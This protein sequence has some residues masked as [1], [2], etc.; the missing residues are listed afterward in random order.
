MIVPALTTLLAVA[1]RILIYTEAVDYR[2]ESIETATAALF[3]LGKTHNIQFDHTEDRTLFNDKNLAKYDA[4]LF[5]NNDEEVLDESGKQ[6]FQ[7]YLNKGGN[8]VGVHGA[9]ACLYNTTFYKKEVGA[10]IDYH[11]ALQPA[12]FLVLDKTHPSTKHLPDRWRYTEEVYHFLQNPRDVGAKVLLSVDRS[13]Y[14]DNINRT[15]AQGSPHPI[16]WYQERGAGAQD[17]SKAGRS[18]FTSLGHLSSTWKDETF[19]GHVLGGINWALDSNTTL[20]RNPKGQVGAKPQPKGDGL[21]EV[22]E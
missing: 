16:A 15:Q 11:P 14:Y 2:H 20:W 21:V 22:D 5:V 10:L 12:T 9:A 17:P 3:Q 18:F 13:S 19:L 7:K 6:A 4:L 1:P 8:Y